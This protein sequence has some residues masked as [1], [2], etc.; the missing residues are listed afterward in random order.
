MFFF[1]S[2]VLLE[3]PVGVQTGGFASFQDPLAFWP[4]I[5]WVEAL[6]PD[7]T[8]CSL[9]NQDLDAPT[10]CSPADATP[11]STWAIFESTFGVDK[12]HETADI[13]GGGGR[14]VGA[15][16]GCPIVEI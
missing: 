10:A 15:R 1:V 7:V 6:S 3:L 16:Q 5:D 2:F 13:D 9:S 14:G 12:P 11:A 8:L 4:E